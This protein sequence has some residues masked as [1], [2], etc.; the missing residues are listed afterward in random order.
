MLFLNCLFKTIYPIINFLHD[1]S[2]LMA[3]NIILS[4]K[5]ILIVSR[6]Y[7]SIQNKIEE[8]SWRIVDGQGRGDEGRGWSK[9]KDENVVLK[10]VEHN[11]TF[12]H[13][14]INKD[15]IEIF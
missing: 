9:I 3:S 11:T 5:L 2:I 14:V 7:F 13:N 8:V 12:G 6:H 10:P 4:F 1:Q 15:G